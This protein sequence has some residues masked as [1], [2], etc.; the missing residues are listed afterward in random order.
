[1]VQPDCVEFSFAAGPIGLHFVRHAAAIDEHHRN[2]AA[3]TEV[4]EGSQADSLGLKAGMILTAVAGASIVGKGYDAAMEALY[5][6][7]PT[8][9]LRLGF[10]VKVVGAIEL[11]ESEMKDITATLSK[12]GAPDDVLSGLRDR[13]AVL[14][15]TVSK[16]EVSSVAH[17]FYR[18][19]TDRSNSISAEELTSWWQARLAPGASAEA[20]AIHAAALARIQALVVELAEDGLTDLDVDGLE[21]LLREVRSISRVG[22]YR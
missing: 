14:Q 9:P 8:R 12:P 4:T 19:D 7:A 20:Q 5:A 11:A 3:V 2:A 22:S 13:L 17:L 10:T 18:L 15:A 21:M 16:A 6:A 1:M